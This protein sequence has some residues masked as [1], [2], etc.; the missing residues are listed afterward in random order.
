MNKKTLLLTGT[1]LAIALA[2]Q[3]YDVLIKNAE[4]QT[5]RVQTDA[6]ESITFDDLE[7]LP[8]EFKGNATNHLEIDAGALRIPV[9]FK[10]SMY[11]IV[12][13]QPDAPWLHVAESCGLSGDGTLT[14]DVDSND[15]DADRTATFSVLCGFTTIDFDITQRM[16]GSSEFVSM[17]DD[18]FRNLIIANYDADGDGRLSLAEAR[19]IV[20]LNVASKNIA[21]LEGIRAMAN[22]KTLQCNDN[23]ITGELN[24]SGL[25]RLEDLNCSYNRIN[26][27]NLSGCS[28][29]KTLYGN[30]NYT[31]QWGVNT[32]Y[33]TEVD[34]TG[35]VA[36]S[37][38]NLQ[39]NALGAIDLS[40]CESLEDLHLEIN[41]IEDID[42]TFNHKLKYA[43]IRNNKLDGGEVDFSGCPDILGIFASDMQLGNIDL[44]G[45][46]KLKEI[47]VQNNR[48][49]SLE[50]PDSHL[51]ERIECLGN[52]IAS[53]DVSHCPDLTTI[54]ASFNEIAAID[55]TN[56]PK[57][58]KLSIGWNNIGGNLDLSHCPGLT[59]LSLQS[60][61]IE[62]LTMINMP[63]LK[64]MDVSDNKLVS[65]DF[66]YMP[67]LV[68]ASCSDNLISRVY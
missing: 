14:I 47:S 21:S 6:V 35:C 25:G 62:G 20:N 44:T 26:K 64:N 4:G 60:N 7:T 66:S 37:Y 15:G 13:S 51:V 40:D 50:F 41:Q 46:T 58:T 45:C 53:L 23:V 3:A 32:F 48:L 55:V 9:N 38:I 52:D 24:L 36:L 27:L 61:R 17:P 22:L 43:H 57:L 54:W 1:G 2:S 11:W 42:L 30:D 18:N 65:L 10:A 59:E 33:L 39:D 31:S 16:V 5:L 19:E 56:C 28:A 63:N 68:Q 49:E 12:S 34:L 29:L 8:F 67:A